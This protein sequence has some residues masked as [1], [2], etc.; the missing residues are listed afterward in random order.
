MTTQPA[1]TVEQIVVQLNLLANPVNVSG[2]QRFGIRPAHQ[3][4]ISIPQLRAIAKGVHDHSLALQLWQ[5]GI[6]EARILA[7]MV[8]DPKMISLDQME[9][10]VQDFDSWDVCD[11]VCSN[12]FDRTVYAIDRAHVWPERQP[13]YVRRAGFTLMAALASHRKKEPDETFLEFLP[14]IIQYSTD[15]R[16]FVRKAVNWALRGIG[17]RNPVLRTAAIHTA[18]QILKIDSSTAH[19]VARDALRELSRP[20]RL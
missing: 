14:L 9:S 7:S 6:H 16:N 15:S 11:Q 18:E 4:G 10:W 17:K 20:E 5:T 3:L 13:E 12:L 1:P 8:D 19:W 2:Q